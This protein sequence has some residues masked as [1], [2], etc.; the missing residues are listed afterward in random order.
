MYMLHTDDDEY[1]FPRARDDDK[2]VRVLN[3]R[4]NDVICC[5]V[6]VDVMM[7]S[8]KG[9]CDLNDVIDLDDNDV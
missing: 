4:M 7:D 3:E 8:K 5:D 2:G 1:W 9:C 6:D